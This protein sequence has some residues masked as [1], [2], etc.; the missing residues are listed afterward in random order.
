MT[1]T[2]HAVIGTLIAARFGN[3]FIA[4]PLA[5]VS[6]LAADAFPH[7]D[8]GTNAK[9]KTKLRLKIEAT[10]DVLAG[11]ILSYGII[12]FFFPTTNLQYTF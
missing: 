7:W 2:G 5:L 12:Y 3:P 9:K 1:A 11:F 10:I 4:I 6:H 8:A